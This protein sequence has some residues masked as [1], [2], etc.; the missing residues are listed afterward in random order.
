MIKHYSGIS[1]TSSL[2]ADPPCLRTHNDI[3]CDD[4]NNIFDLPGIE[5]ID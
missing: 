3:N 5:K 1:L 2:F 4:I